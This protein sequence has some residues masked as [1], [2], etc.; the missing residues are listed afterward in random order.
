MGNNYGY[1]HSK[2]EKEKAKAAF[3]KELEDKY[4]DKQVITIH[5]EGHVCGFDISDGL[6]YGFSW[7]LI[8]KITDNYGKHVLATLFPDNKL[9]YWLREVAF[10]ENN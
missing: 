7:R 6:G 2:A 1:M 8:V 9:C 10:I 5:G 4:L 3:T